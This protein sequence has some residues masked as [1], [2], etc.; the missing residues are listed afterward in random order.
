MSLL[1]GNTS[2]TVSSAVYNIPAQVTTYF[3]TNMT[4]GAIDVE[5]AVEDLTPTIFMVLK[6]TLAADET[7]QYNIPV[8]ILPNDKINITVT[9]S[10][11]YYL[12]IE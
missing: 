11:D 9:G 2:T 7:K 1:R 8:Q 5:M 10:C 3:F 12:N 6:V 4:A